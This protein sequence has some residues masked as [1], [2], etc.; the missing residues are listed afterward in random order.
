MQDSAAQHATTHTVSRVE[1]S[2][3]HQVVL[4]PGCSYQEALDQ[5]ATSGLQYPVLAKPLVSISTDSARPTPAA[6]AA[7]APDGT[8]RSV[9]TSGV[10]TAAGPAV[11]APTTVNDGHTL[12]VIFTDE[13]VQAL[14]SGGTALQPTHAG[15][16]LQQQQQQ[17]QVISLPA[18]LQQYVSHEVLYKVGAGDMTSLAAACICLAAVDG[19]WLAQHHDEGDVSSSNKCVHLAVLLQTGAQQN[20]PQLPASHYLLA[21]PYIHPFF[22]QEALV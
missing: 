22:Q 4:Q 20:S 14:L 19:A 13:G 18:V 11:A 3:P 21:V 8:G 7:V 16:E 1:V 17:Q 2:I 12:G 15:V 5:L 10:A 6:A 9:E